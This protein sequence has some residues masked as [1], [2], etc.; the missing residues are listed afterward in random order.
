[1]VSGLPTA[2]ARG[3]RRRWSSRTS[4]AEKLRSRE[5]KATARRSPCFETKKRTTTGSSQDSSTRRGGAAS[6]SPSALRTGSA[7]RSWWVELL[8]VVVLGAVFV[9][10]LH[11]DMD[12]SGD[13]PAAESAEAG[14]PL[15]R[16]AHRIPGLPEGGLEVDIEAVPTRLAFIAVQVQGMSDEAVSHVLQDGP[17]ASR[18]RP[19]LALRGDLFAVR[20]DDIALDLARV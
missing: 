17:A 14:I 5:W 7:A 4:G 15:G 9:V 1:M 3:S 18:D 13:E 20:V 10:A 12:V 6:A 16:S 8:I 19:H 2:S 11:G